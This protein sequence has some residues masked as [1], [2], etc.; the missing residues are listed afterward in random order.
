MKKRNIIISAV[1]AVR[2]S[3]ASRSS[4]FAQGGI[5]I[6]EEDDDHLRP[7]G[8]GSAPW[9]ISID[10]PFHDTTNDYSP[11]GNGLLLLGGLAGAYLVGKSN[12]KSR[13]D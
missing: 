8:D 6:M 4:A 11:I 5:Y 13:A 2:L 7:G 12:K 10:D 1:F 9:S 3:V